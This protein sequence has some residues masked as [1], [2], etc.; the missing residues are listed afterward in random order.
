MV[1]MAVNTSAHPDHELGY[2]KGMFRGI[3]TVKQVQGCWEGQ[4]ETSYAI[5]CLPGRMDEVVMRATVV[6]RAKGQKSILVLGP[7]WE[8][9][10]GRLAQLLWLNINSYQGVGIFRRTPPGM[11]VQEQG[12]TRDGE[13]FYTI[14]KPRS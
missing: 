9:E 5:T 4:M 7:Y 13:A 3:A 10:G 11:A 12:W 2:M 6:G 14:Q 8:E 1:I